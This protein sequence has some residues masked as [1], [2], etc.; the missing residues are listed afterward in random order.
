MDDDDDVV[1]VVVVGAVELR[2]SQFSL[3]QAD[4]TIFVCE[5]A[6]K[7]RPIDK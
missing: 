1:V 4:D 2:P 6:A 5:H 7:N 3:A